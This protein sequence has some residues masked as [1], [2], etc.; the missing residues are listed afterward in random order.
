MIEQEKNNIILQSW[1]IIKNDTKIKKY[2]FIPWLISI[3]FLT[4][5]LVYQVIYTYV[6]LFD[7]KD[8]V[9]NIILNFFHSEYFIEVV[10]LW[11]LFFIIYIIIMPIFER[12]LIEYISKKKD[13]NEISIWYCL[14]KRIYKFLPFFEY[15]NISSEFK[16]ITIINIYFLWLRFIWMKY[17]IF[18]NY[19]FL[20][21]IIIS[22]IIN[23]LF[24]YTKFEII[25][26]NKK[27]FE[28]ISSSVRL[29]ILNLVLTL[30]I[31]FFLFIV[32]IRI[33]INFL[34]F[35]LF[36]IIIVSA[37]IYITSKIFL[38]ITILLLSIIFLWLILILWY[39]WWVF[40]I[41]KTSIRY[42]TYKKINEKL[43]EV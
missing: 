14:Q 41:F 34:V 12:G 8:K 39:L 4:V 30:K 37:I 29:S 25:L 13:D 1:N 22:S 27:V 20:F 31:F 16:L 7:K 3:I 18:L 26:N 19:V 23:I 32:N 28:A 24:A 35:L 36:P 9:L 6:E 2:Y 33:I 17:I 38:F 40:E 21:L 42:F 15:S 11:I 43:K 5:L 10:I